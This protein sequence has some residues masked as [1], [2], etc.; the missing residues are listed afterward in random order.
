M[1]AVQ[2]ACPCACVLACVRACVSARVQAWPRARGV[3]RVG[4]EG[5]RVGEA[6][7]QRY[8]PTVH[9]DSESD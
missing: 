1:V 4:R 6:S 2:I 8:L 3:V 5:W 9:G 7:G